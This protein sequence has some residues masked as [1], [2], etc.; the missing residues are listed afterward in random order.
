MMLGIVSQIKRLA[1]VVALLAVAGCGF[2]LAGSGRLPVEMQT[3]YL[4]SIEPYSDFHASLVDALR[5]RGLD[6]VDS[7]DEAGAVLRITEDLSD[8][9]V[10]SVSARNVPRE[11]ELFYD[12]TFSLEADGRPL[13]EDELLRARR[14]YTY[15]E[16]QVL[17]KEREASILR[18]A[19]AD[20]LARQVVRRIEALAGV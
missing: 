2:Q 15:D 4:D 11:F 12:V 19:L 9:R 14:N 17:G 16:T 3:T 8:E 13:I 5:E 6:L 10:L 18:Q 7:R 20:D 1:C